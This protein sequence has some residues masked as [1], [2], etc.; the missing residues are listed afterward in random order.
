MAYV[1]DTERI[2][3]QPIADTSTTQNHPLGTIVT[4]RDETY[5]AGEFIY[6]KGVGSTVVGSLV[7]YNTSAGTT[8]LAPASGSALGGSFAVAMSANVANQYGW[9]QISGAAV[10]KKPAVKAQPDS[11]IYL[12]T[13]AGRVRTSSYS[14]RLVLGARTANTTTV[15]TTTSTVTVIINRPHWSGKDLIS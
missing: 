6:L 3:H 7:T 5:G 2:G 13:T 15:T 8:T 11:P 12:S 4:A 9:Y 10:I 14:G 1:L